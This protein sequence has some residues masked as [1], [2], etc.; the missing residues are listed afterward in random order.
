MK[1]AGVVLFGVL[2]CG[3]SVAAAGPTG[4]YRFESLPPGWAQGRT[5]SLSGDTG[6][7]GLPLTPEGKRKLG[8]IEVGVTMGG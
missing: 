4:E 6:T 1:S 2:L 8:A 3:G 7:T 5:A